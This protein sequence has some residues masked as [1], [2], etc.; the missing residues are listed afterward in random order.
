[1]SIVGVR[2]VHVCRAGVHSWFS[3][4]A[5]FFR[6]SFSRFAKTRATQVYATATLRYTPSR[7]F[8]GATIHNCH[9]P[10]REYRVRDEHGG[11][12]SLE[13]RAGHP[14]LTAP[15]RPQASPEVTSTHSLPRIDDLADRRKARQGKLP[16][17]T[18]Y[19]IWHVGAAHANAA[20]IGDVTPFV[21]EE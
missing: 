18:C 21:I 12:R 9:T 7:R 5:R 6:F 16:C 19:A 15:T 20:D 11:E 4:D 13:S 14:S 1:M 8:I 2:C 3:F 17:V 10:L